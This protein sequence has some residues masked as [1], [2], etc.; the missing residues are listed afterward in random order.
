MDST[1]FCCTGSQL[2]HMRSL[3]SP[4]GSSS[5]TRLDL[6]SLL[7]ECRVLATDLGKSLVTGKSWMAVF[8]ET[9]GQQYSQ[10]SLGSSGWIEL[11]M[12]WNEGSFHHN[13][14]Y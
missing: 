6:G 4:V 12:E 14:F 11:A 1:S 9:L 5:L 3:V 8:A 13:C 2:W 10:I 7:W